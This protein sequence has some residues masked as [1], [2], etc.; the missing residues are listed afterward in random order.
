MLILLVF[1][2]TYKGECAYI[3]FLFLWLYNYFFDF[4]FPLVVTLLPCSN[5]CLCLS[6]SVSFPS[7]TS[8]R[9][10][11]EAIVECLN[12]LR[13]QLH[14]ASE[15]VQSALVQ[16]D[17]RLSEKQQLRHRQAALQRIADLSVLVRKLKAA[18]R[19]HQDAVVDMSSDNDSIHC[20]GIA[21]VFASSLA[22]LNS[23]NHQEHE[24]QQQQ[25]QQLLHDSNA[26][27]RIAGLFGEANAVLEKISGFRAVDHIGEQLKLLRAQFASKMDECFQRA[28]REQCL[29]AV[30][31]CLAAFLVS[32]QVKLAEQGVQ[33]ILLH[34]DALARILNSS[35][36]R[37]AVWSKPTAGLADAAN[38]AGD[39]SAE[40]LTDV[41]AELV[42]HVQSTCG[43]VL[44]AS[45]SCDAFV[46]AFDFLLHVVWREITQC[47]SDSLTILASPGIADVFHSNYLT[48]C[49]L[50]QQLMQ[51]CGS[52]VV[53]RRFFTNAAVQEFRS[54][55][56][57]AV[58]FQLRFKGIA[59]NLESALT[60]SDVR[61]LISMEAKQRAE[62][63]VSWPSTSL[64]LAATDA[65][66]AGIRRIW[67]ADVFLPHLYQPSLKLTA[68]ML[69]RLALWADRGMGLR[70]DPSLDPM[71]SKNPTV[72]TEVVGQI[73]SHR[74][75]G[76]WG[77]LT[78]HEMLTIHADLIRFACCCRD[79]MVSFIENQTRK[80]ATLSQSYAPSIKSAH[81]TVA[82]AR[83]PHVMDSVA[84][85]IS[86]RLQSLL[87][88]HHSCVHPTGAD[89]KRSSECIHPTPF[90]SVVID[91]DAILDS[92]LAISAAA[93]E[94][95]AL[96]VMEVLAQ[97]LF[98][99]MSTS[100]ANVSRIKNV[101][102]MTGKAAPTSASQF[103][104]EIFQPVHDLHHMM[105]SNPSIQ[106]PA[107]EH[108]CLLTRVFE[109]CTSHFCTL[110]EQLLEVVAKTEASLQSLQ[111]MKLQTG[112]SDSAA[113]ATSDSDKIRLQLYLD[114]E[115]YRSRVM[116]L[117]VYPDDLDTLR[118]VVRLQQAE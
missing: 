59:G 78:P 37:A 95:R 57:L 90:G 8:S 39:H 18:M 3:S 88:T 30:E 24:Q 101:Y 108:Q 49:R 32:D 72:S 104:A 74:Q 50:L 73:V 60:S 41:F 31:I 92:V 28:V 56:N 52:Q 109:L 112:V 51:L 103:V 67:A 4:S 12:P 114:G 58:Y 35:R 26:M 15:H 66:A 106:L 62:L 40:S 82:T 100:L 85:S 107:H 69:S 54:R 96:L 68:Q 6:L 20:T 77:V 65:I 34:D 117:D 44:A 83:S 16:V 53:A 79:E 99:R 17:A 102:R 93:I 116:A 75:N 10:S 36:I 48:M 84:S 80:L 33:A 29:A 94:F 27:F 21:A 7:P 45:T 118:E 43:V 14:R 61:T 115:E 38:D 70:V 91:R 97:H 23:V 89:S 81:G 111:R 105:Q 55:W 63:E 64:H 98:A 113:A 11:V 47:L 71:Q 13:E 76:G 19:A 25:E 86:S 9:E 110:A 42:L 46:Q 1:H 22:S 2:Q 5:A 87:P